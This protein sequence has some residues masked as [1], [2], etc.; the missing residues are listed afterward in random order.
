MLDNLGFAFEFGWTDVLLIAFSVFVL[1]KWFMKAK[2]PPLPPPEKS[3]PAMTKRDM[4]VEELLEYDGKK[5]ERILLALC[6]T[7]FDVTRGKAY[8]GPYG[9][10]GKLAGHDATRSLATMDVNNVRDEY[11]SLKDLKEEEM[12]EARE[13]YTSFTEKYPT[14]GRLL[15]PGEEPK[16]YGDEHASL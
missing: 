10:Y 9:P 14:V 2:N 13:W 11:D 15:G 5:N 12:N 4:T 6:G 8:Y 3:L 7:I 16:D 1:Y